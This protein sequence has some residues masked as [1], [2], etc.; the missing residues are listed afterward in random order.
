MKS[1]LRPIALLL[2]ISSLCVAGPAKPLTATP[3]ATPLLLSLLRLSDDPPGDALR[4][5]ASSPTNR[6][7]S[8]PSAL[9]A[10]MQPYAAV[11]GAAYSFKLCKDV[12]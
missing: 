3:L 8:A 4:N 2:V 12:A 7:S 9:S 6:M 10:L 11:A 1:S 5:N